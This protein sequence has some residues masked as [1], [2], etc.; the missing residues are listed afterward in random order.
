MPRDHTIVHASADPIRVL[1]VDD[2]RFMRIALRQIIESEGD[3]RVVGEART[4]VEAVAMARELKP[5]AVTMDIEMPEMD[6]LDACASIMREVTPKPAIIMVSA[7]TQTGAAAAVRALHLGAVD[8]V[9]KTSIVA[10]TDL[11]RIDAELR[12]KL[13]AWSTRHRM[14]GGT[15]SPVGIAGERSH[16]GGADVVAIAASTGGPQAL[17]VLLRALGPIETPIVIALHMPEFFTASFAQML[18]QDTGTN[19]Q[20]GSHGLVLAPGSVVLIL[21]GRDGVIMRHRAGGYELRLVKVAAR[22]HPSGD[23]LLESAAMMAKLPV[24]IVLTGM[25]EDGARGAAALQRRKAPILVQ[26]PS[27]CVVDGMPR[28]AIAAAAGARV[29]ALEQMAA[30]LA[31]WCARKP[32]AQDGPTPSDR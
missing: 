19:V 30:T 8:F 2:Q 4:G 26:E 18:G 6:G 1:V 16:E 9:S 14:S 12:P 32:A 23:A 3:I 11:A 5:D 22:V 29:L 25:G 20:E 28:A 10:K 24:G 13:R 7:H 17:T 31:V 21:G 15:A 27:S